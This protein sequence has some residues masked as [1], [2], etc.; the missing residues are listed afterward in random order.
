MII[1]ASKSPRRKELVS[2]YITK[3]FLTYTPSIDESLSLSL[4]DPILI[5]RDIAKRKGVDSSIKYPND[6]VISADTIV[7]LDKEI[8]GKPLDEED[9]FNMLKKLSNRTHQVITAYSIHYK[10]KHILEHVISY[11]TFNN[12]DDE[13]IKKYVASK[14]PLDKAG[15]YG[16]QDNHKYPII[17][18]YQGSYTNIVGLP[19]DEL[20]ESI[21]KIKMG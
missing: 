6:I 4:N 16:I 10:D 18:E 15:G 11:V 8:L 12:L 3:D 2:S 13:L 9:A 5:V 20:I 7:T 17:K 19:M 21:N 14:S 1:L